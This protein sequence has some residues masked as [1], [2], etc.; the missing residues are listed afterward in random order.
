MLKHK[1][2]NLT[3]QAVFIFISKF[4][5]ILFQFLVPIILIRILSQT[6]YGIY[7]KV[8]F[9][10]ALAIPLFKFHFTASLYYFFP[11]SK[12]SNQ[13]NEFISQTYY[14]LLVIC[15]FGSIIILISFFFLESYFEDKIFYRYIYQIL[16]I[17]FF[18]VCSSI[19]ENIFILEKKSKLVV[20]VTSADKFLRTSLLLVI[21]SIYQTIELALLAL[22]IHG[23]LRFLF[24]TI[25]L[26][27]NYKLNILLIK[28]SNLK[29]QW[30]YVMPMGL[31][32]FI[33][34]LGKNADKLILVWL[35]TNSDFAL[36]TI[37]NLSIP[38]IA[39][40]YISIGN[41]IMPELA[42]YSLNKDLDKS[43]MLW[44]SMIIKNSI[45]TIPVIFFFIIQAKE[46]F[47]V[48]FT[49]SYVD[50]ANVFRIIVLT[51]LIQM[52][53]YGYVL[54]AFGKTK[55]ILIAKIY[56]TTLSLLVGYFLIKNFGIIGA[57]L[58]FLFSY[59]IN[60]I[61]QLIATKKL[62]KVSLKEYLPW[63]DFAKLLGI[64]IIPSIIIIY[65]TSL[66]WPTVHILFFNALIYFGVLILLLHSCN[67][68]KKFGYEKILKNIFSK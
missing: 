38:L 18:T 50:S 30:N 2:Y 57:A 68:L 32:L 6:D 63:L 16:A 20:I 7:Q 49:N 35:L 4:I 34:V 10:T 65:T 55:K 3:T 64:S 61:I 52:L 41:V 42:K 62:L 47:I 36:Y 23:F 46:I 54:R 29:T 44:K 26:F 53:G 9:F 67:Y 28:I 17:I 22:I 48:L 39:T 15:I 19:L 58:T 14:Q 40:V 24:L 59:F 8:L 33:G 60:A 66:N 45:I 43:L 11:I 5:Q 1:E 12:K 13:L 27:K 25:Y 56:R 31:G 37:G 51:L 21:I